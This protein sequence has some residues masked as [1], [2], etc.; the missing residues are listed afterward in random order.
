MKVEPEASLS[1]QQGS[2]VQSPETESGSLAALNDTLVLIVRKLNGIQTMLTE[3]LEMQNGFLE[4]L[5]LMC[6]E[7]EGGNR[8]GEEEVAERVD[9]GFCFVL[10]LFFLEYNIFLILYKCVR[11]RRK[12]R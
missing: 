6:E 8:T 12:K 4:T 2:G 5:T 10:F 3:M 11:V 1:Q 9:R 7:N